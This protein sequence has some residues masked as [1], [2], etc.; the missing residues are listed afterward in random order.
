MPVIERDSKGC[1][2]Y[3]ESEE[4][5]QWSSSAKELVLQQESSGQDD[6]LP[7]PKDLRQK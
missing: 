1:L 4:L 6:F 5:K 7:T 2:G 3:L